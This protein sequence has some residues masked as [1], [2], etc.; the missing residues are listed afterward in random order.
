MCDLS[1]PINVAVIGSRTFNDREKLYQ[2]LD[3]FDIDCI[4]SGGARGADTL[5][6]QYANETNIKTK[7]YPA[8]WANKGK[9]AGFIRNK[10]IIVDADLVICFWDGTSKGTRHSI[11]LAHQM[12]KNLLIIRF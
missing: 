12:K 3:L 9:A 10:D 6:E 11:K 7:I 4:I 8:D 1:K 2:V 5:A